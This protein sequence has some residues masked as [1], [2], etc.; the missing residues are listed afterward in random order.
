MDFFNA[1]FKK[2]MMLVKQLQNDLPAPSDFAQSLVWP[3]AQK[4]AF[5]LYLY[6]SNIRGLPLKG[7]KGKF[8]CD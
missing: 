5:I 4:V 3:E 8:S 2:F 6:L 7:A 1:H